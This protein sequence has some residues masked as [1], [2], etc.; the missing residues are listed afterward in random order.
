M[1]KHP[2]A[3]IIVLSWN[4]LDLLPA[5]LAALTPQLHNAELIVVDNG[6]HDGTAQ[7]VHTHWP[8][9]RL[10]ALPKN[11]GFAGGVN[12]G[13]SV[14]RGEYLVLVN[15]D[16]T[17]EPA[18]LTHLLEPLE[19]DPTLGASAGVLLFD[20]EPTCV[21]SAGIRFHRD[22][23]ALDD[24]MIT[25]TRDLPTQPQPV[26][27]ASGG[28][29]AYRRTALQDVGIFDE[30]FFAY[31]EDVDLAWRLNGRNWPTILA[32]QARVRHIYSATGGEGSPLKRWLLARNRWRVLWRSV[33]RQLL[34][35]DWPQIMRY[36]LLACVQAA[37]KNH[38]TIITGR[39]AAWRDRQALQAQGRTIQAR[40]T[41]TLATLDHT[42]WPARSISTI[43]HD[44]HKLTEVLSRR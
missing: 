17:V 9:A 6:S 31:L 43:R 26:W 41:Q 28:A 34:C 21:A 22:G 7:Y 15:N 23:V 30:G 5:C 4:G 27:G 3:S 42:L 20:H 10:L 24:R 32:P 12:A 13:L 8:Q 37:L 33:P 29:V 11:Y 1:T 14:A 44:A 40:Y 38:R 19:R 36:D 2:L 16:A 39:I 18:F 35:R 25:P